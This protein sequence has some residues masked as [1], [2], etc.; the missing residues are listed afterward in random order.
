MVQYML[1]KAVLVCM[2]PVREVHTKV[3]WWSNAYTLT[4]SPV[5]SVV[6][7]VPY[8]CVQSDSTCA[9]SSEAVETGA[10]QGLPADG[11]GTHLQPGEAE[12][13]RTEKRG[14]FHSCNM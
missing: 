12:A 6:S 13:S 2:L 11:G 9:L 4:L 8:A 14:Q 1:V 10:N 7:L 3:E 5:V